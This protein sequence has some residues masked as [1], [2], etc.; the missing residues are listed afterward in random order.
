[1]FSLG[2]FDLKPLLRGGASDE[3]IAS[4][5][6]IVRERLRFRG[7]LSF[8]YEAPIQ[9]TSLAQTEDRRANARGVVLVGAEEWRAKG[10]KETWQHHVVFYDN[11]LEGPEGTFK[12]HVREWWLSV[13]RRY[14]AKIF[15]DQRTRFPRIEIASNR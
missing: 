8:T 5:C 4:L 14:R 12:R 1:M 3:E 10:E 13:S 15:R 11:A 6:E 2:E 9:P 7:D